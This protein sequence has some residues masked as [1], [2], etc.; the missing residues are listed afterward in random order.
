M[1]DDQVSKKCF[2]KKGSGHVHK[3]TGMPLCCGSEFNYFRSKRNILLT[4][5]R[6][7]TVTLPVFRIQMDPGFFDEPDPDF[8]NPDPSVVCYDV[9]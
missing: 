7:W 3:T 5:I 2:Q 8:K 6:I 1:H 9:L 4:R